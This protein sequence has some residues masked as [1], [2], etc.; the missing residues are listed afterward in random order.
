MFTVM[1]IMAF[2]F[3]ISY[4]LL[5]IRSILGFLLCSEPKVPLETSFSIFFRSVINYDEEGS[6]SDE[7]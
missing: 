4:L 5:S 1:G 7:H 3:V 6:Q 2:L